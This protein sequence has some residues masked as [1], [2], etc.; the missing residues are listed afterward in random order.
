LKT[1]T[2][3]AALPNAYFT[4]FYDKWRCFGGNLTFDIGNLKFENRKLGMEKGEWK[5][6][7]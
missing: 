2:A 5:M 6:E 7:S 3:P 4:A 1:K